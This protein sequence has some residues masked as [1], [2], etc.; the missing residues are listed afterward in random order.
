M[1]RRR[2]ICPPGLPVHVVQRGNNRQVCFASDADMKA[3]AHWL[4]EGANKFGVDVHAWVF[5]TNHVHLLLTPHNAAAI[6]RCMQYLGRYYVRY[7]NYRHRRSGTLFEGRFKSSIVQTRRY[8]LA[9]QR[10]IELNSVRAGM[11]S[12]P[13]DYTWSSY[14]AHAFERAVKMWCPHPEYLALGDTGQARM[15][16]YRQFFCE[17]VSAKLITDIRDALNTGLVV[18]N[19][20]FRQEV[21]ALTGQRQHQLKRGPKPAGACHLPE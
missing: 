9:C 2:R 7:F 21:K 10:Y 5:M 4:H 14:R 19:D 16:A 3:Y 20:R 1:P 6:S 18:G 12:D 11:V 17:R 15:S 8:L 13:A